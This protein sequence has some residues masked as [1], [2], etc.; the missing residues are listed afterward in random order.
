VKDVIEALGVPHPEISL[1]L[2]NST[3]V[4]FS[5]ILHSGDRVSVYPEFR[6]LDIEPLPLLRP[7]LHEIRFVLDA[8]LGRLATY[9]R[10]LGFDSS[11]ETDCDDKQLAQISHDEQRILLTRDC[12]LL[13]RSAVMYGYYV[14]TTEP[15]RQVVEVVK[16]F[17][18]SSAT[19]PFSR[20]LTCNSLLQAVPK[21]SVL[22]RLEPKTSR[23]FDEFQL[24]PTC[25]R[26]YWAGSH[27]E[28]MQR[29]MEWVMEESRR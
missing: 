4:D 19:S 28:R 11:Y 29:F 15:T 22:E 23:Y 7:P 25:N 6:T 13:K 16:R 26:L 12:G 5:R 9:L 8:H 18:L 20:C 24:C 3:P 2:V 17:N 10:M 27:Y 21:E 1:I 14:R